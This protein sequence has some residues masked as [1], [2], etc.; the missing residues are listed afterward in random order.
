MS[1]LRV[2]SGLTSPVYVTAPRGATDGRLYVVERAGRI[3]VR[4]GDVISATAAA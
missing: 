2:A 4:S 3:K 1:A